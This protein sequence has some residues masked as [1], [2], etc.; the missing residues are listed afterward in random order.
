MEAHAVKGDIKMSTTNSAAPKMSRSRSS[1]LM[2]NLKKIVER[3]Q[4]FYYHRVRLIK[5]C[6]K[7]YGRKFT[8]STPS[9]AVVPYCLPED[10]FQRMDW[11]F[12][13]PGEIRRDPMGFQRD[14][15]RRQDAAKAFG[16]KMQELRQSSA[17]KEVQK[18]FKV[19]E[20]CSKNPTVGYLNQF[21]NSPHCYCRTTS[22]SNIVLKPNFELPGIYKKISQA[23]FRYD[24]QVHL[25]KGAVMCFRQKPVRGGCKVD[26]A[27]HY[28]D[29]PLVP[30][31]S[32]DN[33]RPVTLSEKIKDP[34]KP[35]SRAELRRELAEYALEFSQREPSEV[36]HPRYRIYCGFAPFEW[37]DSDAN[38]FLQIPLEIL[39]SVRRVYPES[40]NVIPP[41]VA[42][43]SIVRRK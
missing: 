30:F 4:G 25:T 15:L 20:F 10:E 12:S 33:L 7:I 2:R 6:G 11:L 16:K 35:Q 37:R 24:P 43:P 29:C 17:P 27:Y 21:K 41:G 1:H 8:F 9:G 28:K 32:R 3:N 14:V 22:D 34:P 23:E 26:V 31:L 38:P 18:V 5:Y 19:G 36:F 42:R 39:T 13:I 40:S